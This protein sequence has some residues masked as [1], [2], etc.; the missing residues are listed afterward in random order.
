MSELNLPTL[1]QIACTKGMCIPHSP[2]LNIYGY[3]KE[4]DYTDIRPNPDKWVAVDSFTRKGVE[5]FVITDKFRDRDEKTQKLIY[6]SLGSMGSI[7]V[8]LM[9][10]LV[11]ILAKSPHKFIVS[12]GLLGRYASGV[13]LPKFLRNV[14]VNLHMIVE[15]YTKL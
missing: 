4:L 8:E 10:R 3:P 15:H 11:G 9:K 2:F 1:D 6:L 12:K 14:T 7:D 13:M 5:T